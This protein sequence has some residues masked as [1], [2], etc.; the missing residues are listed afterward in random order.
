MLEMFKKVI[1]DG[2]SYEVVPNET[3]GHVWALHHFKVPSSNWND[4]NSFA[5]GEHRYTDEEI[6][7]VIN[8]VL[9]ESWKV[10][11]PDTKFNFAVIVN[12]KF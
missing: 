12:V 6:P 2:M 5:C 4:V 8:Y 9:W 7:I 1:V 11:D 10:S 3:M